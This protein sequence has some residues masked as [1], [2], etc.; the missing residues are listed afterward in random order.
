MQ[1]IDV[2]VEANLLAK[3]TK[4]KTKKRV[5]IKEEPSTSSDIKLDTLVKTIEKKMEKMTLTD[6]VVAREPKGSQQSEILILE[7]NIFKLRRGT[8]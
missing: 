7:D 5:T 1:K 4:M 8:K 6:K 3:K 2:N